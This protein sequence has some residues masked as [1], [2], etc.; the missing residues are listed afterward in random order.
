MAGFGC[1]IVL[2]Q[3]K[4]YSFSD[5]SA[6]FSLHFFIDDSHIKEVAFTDKG[7]PTI[8]FAINLS[9]FFKHHFYQPKLYDGLSLRTKLT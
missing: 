5:L 2:F 7:M 9:Y 4:I 8:E 1:F 6:S 3:E